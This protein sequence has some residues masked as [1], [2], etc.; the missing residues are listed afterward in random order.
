MWNARNSFIFKRLT[1]LTDTWLYIYKNQSTI[2][3]MTMFIKVGSSVDNY[4][5]K[6][7]YKCL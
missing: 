7:W 2:L 5:I 6:N 1:T 3:V 4:E